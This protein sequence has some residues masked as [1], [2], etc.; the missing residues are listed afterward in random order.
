MRMSPRD[1]LRAGSS[2]KVDVDTAFALDALFLHV[3]QRQTPFG[4][5]VHRCS[6]MGRLA[7]TCTPESSTVIREQRPYAI[8]AIHSRHLQ[9]H[10]SPHSPASARSLRNRCR[11]SISSQKKRTSPNHG[12]C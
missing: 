11:T 4:A 10:R 7:S 3:E 9:R 1:G 2:L 12:K 6:N 5:L 8:A